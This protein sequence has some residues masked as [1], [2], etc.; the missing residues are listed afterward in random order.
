MKKKESEETTMKVRKRDRDFL[1]NLF[2]SLSSGK[3]L[4]LFVDMLSSDEIAVYQLIS[5]NMK[6][7]A[8]DTAK[9]INDNY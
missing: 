7:R 6:Q 4:A 9:I 2:P 8:S 1:A 3:A 5:E